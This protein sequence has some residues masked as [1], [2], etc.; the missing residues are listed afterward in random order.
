MI[1]TSCNDFFMGERLKIENLFYCL[2]PSEEWL[3]K[4]REAVRAYNEYF[5]DKKSTP[6][7]TP[8]VE[9]IE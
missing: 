8:N 1:G 4:C 7:E 3:Q 6:Q 5:S 9:V 2:V